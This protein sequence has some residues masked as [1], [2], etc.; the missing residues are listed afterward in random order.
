M[1]AMGRKTYLPNEVVP[2]DHAVSLWLSSPMMDPA[3]PPKSLTTPVDAAAFSNGTTGT[4]VPCSQPGVDGLRLHCQDGEHR[5][6]DAP[7]RLARDQAVDGFQAQ[8]VLAQRQR[9]FAA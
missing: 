7:Q 5:L 2:A 4:E 9:A 3:W 1:D 8:R 6:V